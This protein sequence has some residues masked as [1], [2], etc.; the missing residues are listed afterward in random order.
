MQR[1]LENL[2]IIRALDQMVRIVF[3]V[4]FLDIGRLP[5]HS[6]YECYIIAEKREISPRDFF[7]CEYHKM[8]CIA[9]F[10]FDSIVI[11]NPALS[12]ILFNI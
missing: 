2:I 3:L 9:L 7:Q 12:K 6:G 5:C 4:F 10:I 1:W 8:A 11:S